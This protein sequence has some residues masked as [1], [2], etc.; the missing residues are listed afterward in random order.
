MEIGSIQ[1]ERSLSRQISVEMADR[2]APP[3]RLTNITCGPHYF[4][5]PFADC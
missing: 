4:E 1:R 2:S 5:V 3:L